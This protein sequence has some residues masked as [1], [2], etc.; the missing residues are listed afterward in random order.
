MRREFK[1]EQAWQ[2]YVLTELKAIPKS[3][4]FV[5]PT[6]SRRGIPDIIGCVNGRFVALELKLKKAK[7]DPSRES[8]QRHELK[9]IKEAGA[10]V[11]FERLNEDNWEEV[12]RTI[13]YL[14]TLNVKTSFFR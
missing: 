1:T 14:S 9:K 7:E 12:K 3:Y 2:K 6:K 8:L 4:W 5:P 11:A 13:I 10:P